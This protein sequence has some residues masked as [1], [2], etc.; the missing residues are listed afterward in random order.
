MPCLSKLKTTTLTKIVHFTF[1]RSILR[2]SFYGH[3]QKVEERSFRPEA[4]VAGLR[5][6]KGTVAPVPSLDQ[7][8]A[9]IGEEFPASLGSHADKGIIE[10]VKDKRGYGDVLH[11]VGT[12]NSL[13]IVVGAREAAVSRNDLL[14]EL[15]HGPNLVE[16]VCGV[17]TGV[18]FDLVAKAL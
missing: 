16:A 3:E 9:A 4:C 11:P 6:Q 17:E 13:V 8:H 7:P 10:S 18:E 5:R 15:A 2:S 1:S 14:I 12:G